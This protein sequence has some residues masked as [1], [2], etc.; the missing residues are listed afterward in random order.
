MLKTKKNAG[1]TLIA[2]IITIVVLLILAGVTISQITGSENAMER[3]TEARE[4]DKQGTEL[5]AIKLAVVNSVASDLTGMVNV[6]NLKEGLNGIVE[7][8]GI[9]RMNKDNSPWIVT[10]KTGMK[11][12]INQNGEVTSAEPVVSVE[13]VNTT[14]EIAVSKSKKLQ[15]I[16][17]GASGNTTEANE[18]TFISSNN[19]LATVENDGSIKIVNDDSKIGQT[20]EISLIADG[21]N[22]SN[23]CLITITE[24]V[25]PIKNQYIILGNAIAGVNGE[26]NSDDWK[27]LCYDEEKQKIY[28]IL[29]SYLPVSELP[30][31]LNLG[32]SGTYSVL[33]KDSTQTIDSFIAELTDTSKWKSLVSNTNASIKV[34]G[35]LPGDMNRTQSSTEGTMDYV[36]GKRSNSYFVPSNASS[37]SN[38]M[39]GYWLAS[40]NTN[41][42]GGVYSVDCRL[43]QSSYSYYHLAGSAV[44]PVVILPANIVEQNENGIWEAK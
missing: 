34:Y 20:V 7:N 26:T 17:K 3:A 38:S 11:Y 19:N 25:K 18:I 39:Y 27:I 28:A 37:L 40:P 4:K 35:A 43:N 8:E 33:R 44:C 29:D 23:K 16:A 9:S 1:I 13:F 36:Y 30:E 32:T 22:S 41:D 24:L 42:T 6:D 21:I 12:K 15:I 14:S 10:G 5:E 31:G 2:L